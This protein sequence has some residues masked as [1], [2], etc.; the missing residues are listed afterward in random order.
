[1]KGLNQAGLNLESKVT[2]LSYRIE[3][4][5]RLYYQIITEVQNKFNLEKAFESDFFIYL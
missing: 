5:L 2:E 3:V 1:M 4:S